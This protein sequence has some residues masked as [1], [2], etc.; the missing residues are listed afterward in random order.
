MQD[1]VR[2]SYIRDGMIKNPRWTGKSVLVQGVTCPSVCAPK[3]TAMV[4]TDG[5]TRLLEVVIMKGLRQEMILGRD[6][7]GIWALGARVCSKRKIAVVTKTG[8]PQ[9]KK[10]EDGSGENESREALTQNQTPVLDIPHSQRSPEGSTATCR[11]GLEGED[12]KVPQPASVDAVP[13]AQGKY[14]QHQLKGEDSVAGT[15]KETEE[16]QLDPV[17][18]ATPT[19]EADRT[20]LPDHKPK[21]FVCTKAQTKKKLPRKK[22]RS[23]NKN[24]KRNT[25]KSK[26]G[27]L[28]M[29]RLH[30]SKKGG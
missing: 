14:N 6:F 23:T 22:N 17:D 27:R 16:P 25:N 26:A 15:E 21:V 4:R 2:R 8:Q 5:V 24:R 7:P 18:T 19:N 29:R 11:V 1:P 9:Q 20:D 3:A 30:P 12:D 13:T 28:R 10:K